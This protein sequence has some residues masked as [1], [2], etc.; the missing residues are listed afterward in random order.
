MTLWKSCNCCD[1]G[2]NTRMA[3]RLAAQLL[4]I[5]NPAGMDQVVIAALQSSQSAQVFRS[6]A[7]ALQHEVHADLVVVLQ[8]WPD[9][10][11]PDEIRQLLET[12]PLA[13]IVVVQGAWC[14]SDRRTRM[15]W[16]PAICVSSAG[17]IDRLHRELNVLAGALRPLPWT[18]GLDEVFA[19]D[20]GSESTSKFDES[21]K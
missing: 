6:I 17:T 10:Y 3:E 11:T 9:E 4:L 19:F 18:A 2:A 12:F 15:L 1:N 14:V 16:P 13:R 8:H 7:W 5:G 21:L 20:H